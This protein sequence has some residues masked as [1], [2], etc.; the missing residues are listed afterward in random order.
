M[1]KFKLLFGKPKENLNIVLNLDK[2]DFILQLFGYLNTRKFLTY[3][4]CSGFYQV[5]SCH[6]RDFD[7]SFLRGDEAFRAIERAKALKTWPDTENELEE[8]FIP[9]SKKPISNPITNPMTVDIGF[10]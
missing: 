7:K 10:L 5:L 9:L 4:S 2:R 1:D 6:I 8:I 3:R